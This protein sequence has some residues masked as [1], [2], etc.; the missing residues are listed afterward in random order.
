MLSVEAFSALI[1]ERLAAE[2]LKYSLTEKKTDIS[3]IS[4]F[5]SKN[6]SGLQQQVFQKSVQGRS[7]SQRDNFAKWLKQRNIARG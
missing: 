6:T 7:V 1:S 3:Y 5:L 4:F 2:V